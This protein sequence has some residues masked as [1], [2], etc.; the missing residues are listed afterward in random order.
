METDRHF[1]GISRETGVS[2]QNLQPF[3]SAWPWS[4]EAVCRH[5]Q[6]ELKATPEGESECQE[7]RG[8]GRQYNG[9]LGKMEMS[10][11]RVLLSYVNLKVAQVII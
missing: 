11:V 2:G 6:A 3:M 10:Q 8:T 5:V 7:H 9:H 4:R 1:T